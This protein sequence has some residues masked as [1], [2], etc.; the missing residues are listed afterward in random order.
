MAEVKYMRDAHNLCSTRLDFNVCF[1]FS[2]FLTHSVTMRF[3]NYWSLLTVLVFPLAS[4][5]STCRCF[6][7]DGCWPTDTEWQQ[8]NSSIDGNLI[9]THPIASI[10]HEPQYDAEH[11]QALQKTWQDPITQ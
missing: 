3:A 2:P 6:P 11:C 4:I 5:A 9:R 10:C 8:F 1:N 7:G